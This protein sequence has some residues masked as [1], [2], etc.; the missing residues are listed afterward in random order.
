MAAGKD[1]GYLSRVQARSAG[2]CVLCVLCALCCVC[3]CV[4]VCGGGGGVKNEWNWAKK[5]L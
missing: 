4:C 2:M 3:V 5:K 1:V